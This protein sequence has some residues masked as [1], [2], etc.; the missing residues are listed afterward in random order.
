[1]LSLRQHPRTIPFDR[2]ATSGYAV[3]IFEAVSTFKALPLGST[4]SISLPAISR[5]RLPKPQSLGSTRSVST[6]VAP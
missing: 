2:Y 1:M 4:R 6:G 3:S 5:L